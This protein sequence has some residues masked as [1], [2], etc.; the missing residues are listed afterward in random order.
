MEQFKASF[1]TLTESELQLI[2]FRERFF[3]RNPDAHPS[4]YHQTINLDQ[5][6]PSSSI[7]LEI[8]TL[9]LNLAS[10]ADYLANNTFAI[11]ITQ[12]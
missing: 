10:M 12:L 3:E 2:G 9:D 4:N 11:N 8:N 7:F 1:Y 6:E 5:R